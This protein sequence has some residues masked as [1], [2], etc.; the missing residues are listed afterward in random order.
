MK[1]KIQCFYVTIFNKEKNMKTQKKLL[2][3]TY[4]QD[5]KINMETKKKDI[6]IQIKK[7][8]EKLNQ[9]KSDTRLEVEIQ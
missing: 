5:K 2:L 9:F 1:I 3:L 6:H 8:G 4:T 7:E